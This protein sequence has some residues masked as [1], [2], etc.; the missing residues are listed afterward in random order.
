MKVMEPVNIS[1]NI[2]RGI[3][4]TMLRIRLFEE[5]VADLLDKGEIRCPTHLY[6]GQEAIAVGVCANLCK[7]DYVFSTHRSHGHY[8]AKG[9][10]LKLLMA[11]L[12][13]KRTG[14]SKGKG[15]SMHIV[16]PE[17]GFMGSSSIVS[18]NIPLAVGAA[19]ASTI[20]E[21]RKVTVV[22]FGDGATDEG[23]FHESLNF[24]S[25]HK[26]S[27]IFVCENNFF[28][29]H[30]PL[31]LRQPGD[32]IPDKARVH[33]MPGIR[34]DGNNPLEVYQT[35][36]QLIE[37]ACKGKGP[38][39]MECR[40]FRWRAHVG[41][42]WDLDV[43]HRKKEEVEKWMK[44]CPIKAIEEFLLNSGILS[45]SEKS[46]IF[47]QIKEEVEEALAFAKESPFPD[48]S[49]LIEDVFKI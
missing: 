38:A 32:N 1:S 9:G 43:G 30:L 20:Q 17:V 33:L 21:N 42:W 47:K 48:E 39:L 5:K 35:F 19:L 13:G 36:H 37:D 29:T 12:Y 18:S 26:L 3:Y 25:L 8:I 23:V 40:T 15:G 34:V 10:D 6:I 16:A 7:D 2:L 46:Q 27:I 41:P 22:F 31:Y 44:R 49:E 28:S 14:C 4:I 24:A 11:E 45:D